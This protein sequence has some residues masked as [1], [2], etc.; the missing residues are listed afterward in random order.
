M[1]MFEF[2]ASDEFRKNLAENK[3]KTFENIWDLDIGWFEEKNVRRG[4]WSGVSQYKL[5][6]GCSLFIKR[7]ENHCYR[8]WTDLFISKATFYREYKNILKFVQTNV[9]T[10]EVLYFGQRKEKGKLQA[11]LI[12]RELDGYLSLNDE[13]LKSLLQADFKMRRAVIKKVSEVVSNMHNHRLQHNCL[14]DKHIFVKP[15]DDGN[16]DVRLIDLEKVKWQFSKQKAMRRDLSALYRHSSG[17][18]KTDCLC[19]FLSYRKEKKLT[20]QS[21]QALKIFSKDIWQKIKK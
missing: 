15:L 4:G 19:F 17:W 10:L 20:R 1:K 2:L 8:A 13:K 12:T 11:I 3:L 14:Y 9:P 16:V 6:D 5:N 18:S 7:Q 21:K